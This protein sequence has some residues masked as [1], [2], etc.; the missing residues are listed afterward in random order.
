MQ[1]N[2]FNYEN[3]E[4]NESVEA[5][6]NNEFNTNDELDV[7][8][9]NSNAPIDDGNSVPNNNGDYQAPYST[10]TENQGQY[11]YTT[12]Y[13]MENGHNPQPRKK[14]PKAAFAIIS[15]VVISV[16]LIVCLSLLSTVVSKLNNASSGGN[17]QLNMQGEQVYVVK[18]SPKMEIAE[19]TDVDYVPQSIPEVVQ[20]IGD[21][22]VEISTS[23]VVNDRFFHQYVTSGAGSGVIITESDDAGYLLTN[24]HVIDGATEITV[25]LTNGTEY[26][27]QLLGSDAKLDLAALRIEKLGGEDFTTAPIGNSGNLLVGQQVI[28]IGN[29]LG[30]LGGTVTDGI[31]SALDRT[32]TIDNV[33][34]V[35]LQHNAAINP[36]NSGG[37]LF[38]AMGNLIGIVNAK[39][40]ETG[41]EGLGFAIPI[42]IA[43]G[44]F[45]R[46]M[47]IEPTLGIR[48]T[49]GSINKVVG[50]Y[51]TEIINSNTDFALYDKITAINSVRIDT[52]SDYY[53]ILEQLKPGDTASF[54]VT[55]NNTTLTINVTIQ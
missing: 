4:N 17:Q 29:P 31:I 16:L 30:S 37:G 43:Y 39:T 45:N 35:L 46:V 12:S 19:N 2:N 50:V 44:F 18:N 27:A 32:V 22:V 34:M 52:D 20:K 3:N 10:N 5:N 33:P 1:E 9:E 15:V 54:R 26:R 7:N 28:A 47:V 49:Y 51:V 36:G 40:S 6:V 13:G 41:I 23:S 14:F 24:H 48:V 53:A 21:S 11:Y 25:R 38:D 8:N 42:D 55:R